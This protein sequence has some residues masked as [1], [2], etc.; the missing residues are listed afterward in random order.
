LPDLGNIR[1]TT[2]QSSQNGSDIESVDSIKYFA[3]RI[4]SSQYRAV[5]ARDYEAIIKKGTLAHKT[6][7]SEKI[8]ER[9]RHRYEINNEYIE[10]LTK[11]IELS[12][13]ESF[14]ASSIK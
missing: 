8:S 7:K 3:P 10:K 5:T 6:Y 13:S 1:V 12:A 9:H 4:Y 11:S 2:N 14:L